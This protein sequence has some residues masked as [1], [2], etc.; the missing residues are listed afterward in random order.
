LSGIH[1]ETPT[2]RFLSSFFFSVHTLATIGYGS[3]SPVSIAAN[4]LVTVESLIGLL[5]LG[6]V[7][8]VMFAKFSRPVAAFIFS[9]HALI[10]P[11]G[12]DKAF[13]FRIANRKKNQLVELE[14]KLLLVR[15]IHSPDGPTRKFLPLR[16]ERDRV[17]FFPLTWT[18]VHPIDEESP[19]AGMTYDDL[20]AAEAEFIV[21][22]SAIDETFSGLVHGR[23]SYKADEVVW[24]ARFRSVFNQVSDDGVV[25][26]NLR[27]IHDYEPVET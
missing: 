20:V 14:A 26:V 1:A 5:G 15:W 2:Q 12:N 19:L 8:G 9:D 25:S 22:L 6:L 27:E 7:A 13:M 24:G 21:L 10:A 16:L 11:Y 18:I 3:I 4:V 23:T 17:A